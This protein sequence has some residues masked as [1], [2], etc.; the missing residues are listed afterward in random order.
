MS[1]QKNNLYEFEGFTIDLM[2]QILWYE[3]EIVGLTPKVLETLCVLVEHR[4]KL[5]TKDELIDILWRDTYVE[6]RNLTQNIFLLRKIFEEKKGK[7]GRKIIKTVPKKGYQFVA[8]VSP[9][10]TQEET[11]A[12]THT[13]QLHITAEGFASKKDLTD[14]VAQIAGNRNIV[15]ENE[16]LLS[17]SSQTGRP[18]FSKARKTGIIITVAVLLAVSTGL[19]F[20]FS[21]TGKTRWSGFANENKPLLNFKRLTDSGN[22]F[23]P[24]VSPD[25][26]FVA[27]VYISDNKFS[28]RLRHIATQSVT[29]ALP[30]VP[31]KI[32]RPSFSA[33]GNYLFYR[34]NRLDPAGHGKIYRIPIFGGSP[35]LMIEHSTSVVSV[36]PD[37]R[38]L[39]YIRTV[40]EING[41]QL[42]IC[43]SSDGGGERILTERKGNEHFDIWNF[44]PAWSPDGRRILVGL[45]TEPTPEKPDAGGRKFGALNVADGSFEEIKLPKWNM[46]TEAVWMPDGN[47]IL[48]LARQ[49]ANSPFQ[50]WQV[51][52]PDGTARRI[53]NDTHDYKSLNI[54]S[55][56]GFLLTTQEKE[57]FNLW[58]T[59]LVDPSEVKRLT[60]SS[61][62]KHGT[63]GVSWT[64]DGKKLVHTLAENVH[65]TNLWILDTETLEK[66][67]LTFDESAFNW[68]P[69]VTP[70]GNS[71]IFASNRKNGFH[72]WRVNLDGTDL[73]QLTDGVGENFP[74]ITSDGKWLIYVTP[75]VAPNTI[76]KKSLT[77]DTKPFKLFAGAAG[78]N[79]ISPDN[80]QMIISYFGRGITDEE[81]FRYGLIPFEPTDRIE[82]LGFNP[83]GLISGGWKADG[84]GFYYL[85]REVETNNIW[86][87]TFEDRSKRKITDFREMRIAQFAL[88]PDGN[89]AAAARG[90]TVSN[91]FKVSGF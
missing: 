80:R 67:Q 59:S 6:D 16:P 50:I 47:G 85:D 84:K 18:L 88:S 49:A 8:D 21:E 30:P 34:Q 87:Y 89:S 28:I 91:I 27:Y 10:V 33:D 40:P 41:Q 57:Y 2:K 90:E 76:W 12:V 13:R 23:H 64:P 65:N 78:D 11:I 14:A 74:N 82:D 26:Q 38:R 42:V 60:D 77:S 29:V 36:S 63:R 86:F 35:K 46:H 75:G 37:G 69:R 48:F 70:D 51:S 4:G 54:A 66:R 52:Y 32:S 68:F 15:P 58:L 19:I 3:N 22:A 72:I 56:G 44:Y 55:D 53:T 5:L 43:R 62:I 24:A 25:G 73:R 7:T 61:E 31:D 83:N 39:A 20:W 45:M 9:V 79:L 71:V 81:K 1:L 17:G